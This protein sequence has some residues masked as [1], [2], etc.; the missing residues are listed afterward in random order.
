MAAIAAR[1][2][3]LLA[4]T[5]EE[6]V[7]RWVAGLWDRE[8]GQTLAQLAARYLRASEQDVA[9]ALTNRLLA[10]LAR[11]EVQAQLAEVV[12]ELLASGE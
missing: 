10:A 2:L 3:Q 9:E 7:R 5:P 11:P 4:A 1:L 12:P 8:G 6:T